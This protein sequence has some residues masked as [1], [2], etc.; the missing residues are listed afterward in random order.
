MKKRLISVLI[1]VV[2]LMVM[3][4]ACSDEPQEVNIADYS[5]SGP[6][7][8]KVEA[9]VGTNLKKVIVTWEAANNATGYNVYY[10]K[11]GVKAPSSIGSGLNNYYTYDGNGDQT[12]ASGSPVYNT[13]PNK[14][15]AIFDIPTTTNPYTFTSGKYKFG[16]QVKEVIGDAYNYFPVKWSDPIDVTIVTV[17]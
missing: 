17:P 16:V 8:G 9:K 11:E 6:S 5:A 14:W 10:Q 2:F 3:F 4:A 15:T 13:D 7:V 12:Y 1:A